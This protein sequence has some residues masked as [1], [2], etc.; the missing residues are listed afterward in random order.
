M[1][2]RGT[3]ALHGDRFSDHRFMTNDFRLLL[4]A[5]ACNLLVRLTQKVVSDLVPIEH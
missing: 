5:L 4:H 2:G 3:N 1:S